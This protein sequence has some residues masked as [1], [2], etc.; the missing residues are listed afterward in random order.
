MSTRTI[1]TCVKI[2]H[3]MLVWHK[4]TQLLLISIGHDRGQ[5]L[6]PKGKQTLCW[7]QVLFQGFIFDTWK[8]VKSDDTFSNIPFSSTVLSSILHIRICFHVEDTMIVEGKLVEV[9]DTQ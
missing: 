3:A 1:G 8:R 7:L 4:V 6:S 5:V 2:T 9:K